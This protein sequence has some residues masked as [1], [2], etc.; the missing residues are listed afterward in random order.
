M[1]IKE[2]LRRINANSFYGVGPIDRNDII[3]EIEDILR[4]NNM[5]EEK[6]IRVVEQ[7]ANAAISVGRDVNDVIHDT[8][9]V[10]YGRKNINELLPKG[11][12]IA[13]DCSECKYEDANGGAEPCYRCYNKFFDVSKYHFSDLGPYTNKFTPK[14]KDTKEQKH[15]EVDESKYCHK[16]KYE[17]LK[18]EEQPCYN[19]YWNSARPSFTPKEEE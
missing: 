4:R 9:D 15:V 13:N 1:D 16:C 5:I 8:I 18:I 14:E 10:I 3:K 11:W 12:I 6:F 7:T 2:R 19:C 17:E